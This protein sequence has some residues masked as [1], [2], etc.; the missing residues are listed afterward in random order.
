[1]VES[2]RLVDSAATLVVGASGMDRQMEQMMRMMNQNVV[3]SKKILE[4]NPSHPLIR[5]L[6]QIH[7]NKGDE[8]LLKNCIQQVY[9]GAL[10]IDGNMDTPTEFVS[11]M[12]E[13]MKQ[14]TK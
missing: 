3:G 6:A 14:A 2:K 1:M 9:E 13:I 8:S 11:R 7:Q 5:N 12:T 4:I 10:L